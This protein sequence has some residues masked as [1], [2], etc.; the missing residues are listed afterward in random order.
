MKMTPSACPKCGAILDTVT[1]ADPAADEVTPEPND[2]TI[3]IYCSVY[4]VFNKDMSF[5]ILTRR[6]RNRLP[7][8]VRKSLDLLEEI[9]R[10]RRSVYEN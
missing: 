10:Q 4:L 8:E 9:R 7:L 6:E 1:V 5:H 3:C 2:I